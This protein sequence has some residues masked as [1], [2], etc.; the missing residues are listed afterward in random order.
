MKKH[1]WVIPASHVTVMLLTAILDHE[2]SHELLDP[3]IFHGHVT[4]TPDESNAA[5]SARVVRLYQLHKCKTNS[6]LLPLTLEWHEAS[7]CIRVPQ[8]QGLSF[9]K[10]LPQLHH[11]RIL[12]LAV[13]IWGTGRAY[14]SICFCSFLHPFFIPP[15]HFYWVYLVVR[16][17]ASVSVFVFRWPEWTPLPS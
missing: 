6:R 14:V 5:N 17:S 15:F 16:T 8:I 13:L 3:V 4:A 10:I 7:L 12:R 1:V 11:A 2:M 9:L